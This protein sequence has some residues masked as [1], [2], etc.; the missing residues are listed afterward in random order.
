MFLRGHQYT[1]IEQLG[2]VHAV[3]HDALHY[4]DRISN[5]KISGFIGSF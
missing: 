3:W 5:V 2:N 4:S 1:L